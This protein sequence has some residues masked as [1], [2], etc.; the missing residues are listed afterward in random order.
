[1]SDEKV[2]G[3]LVSF[4]AGVVVYTDSIPHAAEA[5]VRAVKQLEEMNRAADR[6]GD[7]STCK[8]CGKPIIW[9]TNAEQSWFWAHDRDRDLGGN[10]HDSRISC[11]LSA[12][13]ADD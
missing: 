13:P 7:R 3:P 10:G 6:Y 2:P 1:M 12:A 11:R 8:N 4:E 5:V 9:A